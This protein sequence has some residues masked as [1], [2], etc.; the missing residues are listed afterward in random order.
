MSLT[1]SEADSETAVVLLWDNGGDY[2]RGWWQQKCCSYGPCESAERPDRW[3]EWSAPTRRPGGSGS[4]RWWKSHLEGME[5]RGG[6]QGMFFYSSSPRV[7]EW[8]KLNNQMCFRKKNM[9][10]KIL[11]N[12]ELASEKWGLDNWQWFISLKWGSWHCLLC[13]PPC[14]YIEK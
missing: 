11:V 8:R 10:H 14:F 7:E 2:K 12:V 3:A 5:G 9:I 1:H 4:L 13:Y 6:D